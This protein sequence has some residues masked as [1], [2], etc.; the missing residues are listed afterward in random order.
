MRVFV[1][2]ELP[3]AIKEQA[4]KAADDLRTRLRKKAPRADVR[5]VDA[6]NLHITIWFIGEIDEPRVQQVSTAL[7]VPYRSGRFDLRIEGAGAF[8]PSGAPRVFWLGIRSGREGLTA[9]HSEV[10]DRLVRQGFEAERRPYSPHLTLARVKDIR[11][12]AV[13]AARKTLAAATIQLDGCPVEALTLFRSRLSPKG[14]QYESLL[15]VPL[16]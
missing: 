15:R 6:A 8:P 16:K 14:A 10:Q 4:A 2:I 3:D 7:S 11:G 9:L 12:A 13:R 5:W 1:G